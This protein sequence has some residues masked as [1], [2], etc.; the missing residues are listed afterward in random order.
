MRS[1]MSRFVGTLLAALLL[2]LQFPGASPA[3]LLL[4][5]SAHDPASAS[6]QGDPAATVRAVE[7]TYATCGASERTGEL[8]GL[9]NARDRHR[10]AAG[11]PSDGLP[12]SVLSGD[13]A[14]A[15]RA[16]AELVP[17]SGTHHASRSSDAHRP[18]VLQVFRC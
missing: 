11:A 13:T 12:R 10:A 17:P 15:V 6:P 14:A 7:S 16:A 9:R 8:T 18:A 2:A 4:A 5:Y 1:T 3:P